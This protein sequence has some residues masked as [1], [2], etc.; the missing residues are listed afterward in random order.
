MVNLPSQG[1][2]GP[3]TG[4]LIWTGNMGLFQKEPWISSWGEK[5]SSHEREGRGWPLFGQCGGRL[6]GKML[7]R[8]L[9]RA[10]AEDGGTRNYGEWRK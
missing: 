7:V 5:P 9:L 2:L 10:Y 8:T 4:M 6:E 1:H 3:E